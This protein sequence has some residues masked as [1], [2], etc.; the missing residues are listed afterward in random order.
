MSNEGGEGGASTESGEGSSQ[1][2]STPARRRKRIRGAVI[3]RHTAVLARPFSAISVLG[4]SQSR[5]T[6]MLVGGGSGKALCLSLW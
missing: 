4:V 6:V 3:N 2:G 5:R 1:R